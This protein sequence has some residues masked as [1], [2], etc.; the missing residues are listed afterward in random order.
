MFSLIALYLEYRRTKA[1][2]GT[3]RVVSA[4]NTAVAANDLGASQTAADAA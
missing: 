2:G 1:R 3:A 4:T